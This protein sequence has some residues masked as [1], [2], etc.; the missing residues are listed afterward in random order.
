[1]LLAGCLMRLSIADESTWSVA[2]MLPISITD[3]Q[4]AA[5]TASMVP[6]QNL[7]VSSTAACLPGEQRHTPFWTA[8]TS[9][10]ELA[11]YRDSSAKFSLLFELV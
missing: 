9:T 11:S 3:E 6:T 7:V 4:A 8:I 1:M 10:C 2:R 5:T